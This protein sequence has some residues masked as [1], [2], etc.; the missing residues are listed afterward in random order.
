M[1][2]PLR[3]RTTSAQTAAAFRAS[4]ERRKPERVRPRLFCC[5]RYEWG[6]GT[7]DLD[8][9]VFPAVADRQATP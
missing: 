4:Y 8:C 3:K 1:P 7:H 6:D 5:P 2:R 9:P